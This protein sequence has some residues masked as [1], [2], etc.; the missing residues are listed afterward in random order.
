MPMR[1]CSLHLNANDLERPLAVIL[2][3]EN[4]LITS[5]SENTAHTCY[6]VS[7]VVELVEQNRIIEFFNGVYTTVIFTIYNIL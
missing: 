4:L 3:N 2:A 6:T 7:L 1:M 5:L